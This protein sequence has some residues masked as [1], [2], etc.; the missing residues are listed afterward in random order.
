MIKIEKKIVKKRYYLDFLNEGSRRVGLGHGDG[1]E[2]VYCSL[3]GVLALLRTMSLDGFGQSH[4]HHVGWCST[5][6]Q[7][8]KLREK[9]ERRNEMREKRS[10]VVFSIREEAER[11]E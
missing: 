9:S 3:G 11:E 5:S 4:R 6:I 10:E 1:F 8:R 2:L 7:E